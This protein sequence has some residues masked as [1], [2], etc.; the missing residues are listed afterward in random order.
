MWTKMFNKTMP[1]NEVKSEM[2]VLITIYM[3]CDGLT[4]TNPRVS[5]HV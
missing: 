5:V 3:I 2:C 1:Q 4:E